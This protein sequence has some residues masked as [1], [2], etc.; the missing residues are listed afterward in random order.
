M[1]ARPVGLWRRVDDLDGRPGVEWQPCLTPKD[2]R[3]VLGGTIGATERHIT[4]W[5][6]DLDQAAAHLNAR[7]IVDR[8]QGDRLRLFDHPARNLDAFPGPHRPAIRK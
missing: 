3:L 4:L 6:H 2:S 5:R 8:R 7:F 1:L